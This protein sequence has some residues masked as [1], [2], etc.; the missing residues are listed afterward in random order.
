MSFKRD[1]EALERAFAPLLEHVHDEESA[2]SFLRLAEEIACG[3]GLLERYATTERCPAECY[4]G[5][6]KMVRETRCGYKWKNCPRCR[7]KGRV[8]RG[9]DHGGRTATKLL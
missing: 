8:K 6:I 2:K 5:K 1:I 9:G 4:C 3:I 7:G